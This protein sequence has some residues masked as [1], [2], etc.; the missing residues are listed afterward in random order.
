MIGPAELA[1]SLGFDGRLADDQTLGEA[2]GVRGAFIVM[3]SRYASMLTDPTESEARRA[4]WR[5]RLSDEYERVFDG[6]EYRVYRR[7]P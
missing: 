7:R 6:G 2:S 5:R 4:R 3:G 1:F